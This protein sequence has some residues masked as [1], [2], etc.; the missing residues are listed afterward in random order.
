MS[1]KFIKTKNTLDEFDLTDVE[2]TVS[3]NGVT[4]DEILEEFKLF[5]RGC[6]FYFDGKITIV[7]DDNEE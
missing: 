6:G 5:L 4:L 1:Y 3:D 2:F 7:K